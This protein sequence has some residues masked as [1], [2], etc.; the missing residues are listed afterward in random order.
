MGKFLCVKSLNT[1]QTVLYK[2]THPC[3]VIY[4]CVVIICSGPWFYFQVIQRR[5]MKSDFKIQVEHI[6]ERWVPVVWTG[7]CSLWSDV[8]RIR[9]E[10]SREDSFHFRNAE[11]QNTG[12]CGTFIHEIL[13]PVRASCVNVKSVYCWL[14]VSDVQWV[15][16]QFFWYHCEKLRK[17]KREIEGDWTFRSGKHGTVEMNI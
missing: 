9:K 11:A 4:H 16:L 14:F 8:W 1:S 12:A 13:S 5:A 17:R 7:D 3:W 6:N 10:G 15:W 2:V